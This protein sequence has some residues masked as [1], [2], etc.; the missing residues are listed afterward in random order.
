MIA[1]DELYLGDGTVLR[2]GELLMQDG[3]IREVGEHVSHPRGATVVRGKACMP[4]MIDAFGHLGLEGSRK[5]PATDFALREIVEPGDEL[6]RRVAVHGITTVVLTPRA[7][8]K[9]GAP[10]M[11]YKPAAEDFEHQVVGDLVAL[12][13]KW[14]ESNRLKSGAGVKALLAKAKEY[15][16]KWAE[17]EAAMAVWTPPPPEP[18][19]EDKDAE[20]DEKKDDEE[21]KKDEGKDDKKKKKKK[22]KD[23][24]EVLE[25][26]PITGVW[27]AE[28]AAGDDSVKLKLRL[29]FEMAKG[30]G[31]VHGN[32]R[33]TAV[34]DDLVDVEGYWNREEKELLLRGLG[35][36]GWV[37]VTA[38]P[39]KAKLDGTVAVGE[40]SFEFSAERT[41]KEVVVAKR[42]ERRKEKAP[43]K[44]KEPK[45]KPKK[46]KVDS[47]LEPLRRAMEGKVTV[48]I[49]V[50]RDDE[51]LDCVAAFEQCGIR[52]VLYG[53][54]DAYKVV[55]H[56]VG[57][58]A[59][60]L[61]SPTVLQYDAKRGTDY[62]TPYSDYQNAG[63]PV[64]FHS[65]AEE[66]AAGLPLAAAYAVAQGMSPTGAL[67]ALTADSAA[68]MS[69]GDRVGTLERGRDADVLLLDDTPLAPGT[70]ILRA[71]VNGREVRQP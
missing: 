41:S 33:S 5:V 26:D 66:G 52:P 13:L 28:L 51:I 2:P 65:G 44:V 29:I 11:A 35:S 8:S 19:K 31:D 10:V 39:K 45:G 6:D 49:E 3:R 1:V 55:D 36:R 69:I 58:V 30:S 62:R 70:S 46:P 34:S 12:R 57:R 18:A 50:Q 9:S 38:A 68:M 59:G 21:E 67:R 47:K 63:I 27:E 20:K 25:P 54:S 56:L 43:P 17:Y 22:Q 15:K 14:T 71:W 23:E 61:L 37:T 24:E 53:A 7:A 64:A 16:N 4:G 48:V 42:Q 60:I 32:L 40:Q